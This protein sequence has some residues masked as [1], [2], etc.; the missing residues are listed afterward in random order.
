M[1]QLVCQILTTANAPILGLEATCTVFGHTYEG[2]STS[3]G[4][5]GSWHLIHTH[6]Y[7][8]PKEAIGIPCSLSFVVTSYLELTDIPWPTIKME[9]NLRKDLT[10]FLLVRCDPFNY[11]VSTSAYGPAGHNSWV[12]W[13]DIPSMI[14]PPF[15]L[16][17]KGVEYSNDSP[18]PVSRDADTERRF[19]VHPNRGQTGCQW[20]P[21]TQEVYRKIDETDRGQNYSPAKRR[22]RRTRQRKRRS[23][24]N[25]V[26]T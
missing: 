8:T 13:L 7:N 12:P 18:Q 22:R 16:P 23:R 17:M 9:L 10:N 2:R 4:I 19:H 21:T 14:D 3:N 5:I 26:C 15:P 1:A 25:G 6:P 24:T 20:R 11:N